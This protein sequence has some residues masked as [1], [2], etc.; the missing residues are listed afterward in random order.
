LIGIFDRLTR[1]MLRLF[2]PEHAHSL[3][4]MALKFAP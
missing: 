2:D 3:A 1:P 4:I